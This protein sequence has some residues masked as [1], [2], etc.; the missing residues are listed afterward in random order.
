MPATPGYEVCGLVVLTRPEHQHQVEQ[1]LHAME[2]VDIHAQDNCG[3]FAIT[4]EDNGQSQ[5]MFRKITLLQDLP[6]VLDV[7]FTY[8]HC[9]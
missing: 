5:R 3:R 4:I 2:G 6:E 8:G 9:D 7:S 1:Q